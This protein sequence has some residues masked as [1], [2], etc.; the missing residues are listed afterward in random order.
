MPVSCLHFCWLSTLWMGW[1]CAECGSS[2]WQVRNFSSLP[3]GTIEFWLAEHLA[4]RQARCVIRPERLAWWPLPLLHSISE[5]YGRNVLEALGKCLPV[6]NCINMQRTCRGFLC[7]SLKF[8]EFYYW[9]L[10]QQK[11]RDSHIGRRQTSTGCLLTH[12]VNTMAPG[13]AGT[14]MLFL[15]I[16]PR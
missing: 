4:K 5:Q 2:A 11:P 10:Q 16:S 9:M 12:H 13:Y 3:Q 15:Q 1:G 14:R 8:S 7:Q 6:I